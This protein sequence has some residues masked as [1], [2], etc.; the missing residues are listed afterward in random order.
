[1]NNDEYTSPALGP[2]HPP[3]SPEPAAS[4]SARIPSSNSNTQIPLRRPRILNRRTR[5]FSVDG[6]SSR[7]L[8]ADEPGTGSRSRSFRGQGRKKSTKKP[9][10]ALVKKLQF[11]TNI[12]ANLDSLVYVQLATL[13]YMECSLFLL[14]PRMA[15]H[16]T[17]LTPQPDNL[18]ISTAAPANLLGI[19][20]PNTLAMIWHLLV[21]LPAA[22][23]TTRGYFHG[24]II[25]DFIG[26]KPPATRLVLLA[27]DLFI[28]ILQLIMLAVHLDRDNL[29]TQIDPKRISPLMLLNLITVARA[30][31]QAERGVLPTDSLVAGSSVEERPQTASA[32]SSPGDLVSED[33]SD[34]LSRTTSE[35]TMQPDQLDELFSGTAVVGEYN[36]VSTF[37]KY[38]AAVK[39]PKIFLPSSYSSPGAPDQQSLAPGNYAATLRELGLNGFA[40]LLRARR[41][42]QQTEARAQDTP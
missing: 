25:I 36:L 20:I 4:A 19:I 14:L 16:Y 35:T 15:A 1:M 12:L 2:T 37:K 28:L 18:N 13:Y 27:L 33:G 39:I 3:E 32:P 11:I 17:Y 34:L 30:L 9:S 29:R 10:P 5:S 31:D 23:E 40:R 6:R 38:A 8:R 7:S 22:P 42:V 41:T 24:G 26:Q 21:A